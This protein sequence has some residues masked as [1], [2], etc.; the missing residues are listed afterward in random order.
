MTC[1]ASPPSIVASQASV[2]RQ[3]PAAGGSIILLA[4]DSAT[5]VQSIGGC[6][7]YG[8]W[9]CLAAASAAYLTKPAKLE[10]LAERVARAVLAGRATGRATGVAGRNVE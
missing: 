10:A 9:R 6:P 5:K 3:R 2:S 4:E 8:E 1:T 7:E